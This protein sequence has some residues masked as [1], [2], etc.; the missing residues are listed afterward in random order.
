MI[1]S[2]IKK[3]CIVVSSLG[4]GGA[5][6]SSALLSEMLDELGFEVHII[7]VLNK[8]NY[9]Y[10]GKLLNLGLL[11]SKDDSSW[12][13]LK[14]LLV[15]K[16]YLKEHKFDYIIDNRT[17]IGLKE[18]FIAK[19]VYNDFKVI[20]GVHSYNIHWY[21]HPNKRLGKWLYKSAYQLVCVSQAIS[22]KLK[23][24]YDFQNLGVIHNAIQLPYEEKQYTQPLKKDYILFYGRIEDDIKNLSMLL[25]SYFQ[26]K[27]PESGIKLKIL[28]DGKDKSM[29][30]RKVESMQKGHFV[31][32]LDFTSQPEE[33][34]QNA[35]LT[36][37]TSRNEG[38]PMVLVESLSLGVPVV[39]VDC[40]SG[41]NEIIINE[42][43]G[44]LVANYDADAFTEALNRMIE[45]EDLY[46]NCK[47]NAI[48]SVEKFS[49]E[50]IGEQWKLLL[51]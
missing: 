40:E 10:K 14:R 3:V 1:K 38:F 15:F 33:I 29:L 20:Y 17:R 50:R 12:G 49:T 45:D 36:V 44:L 41:P 35:F 46:L 18:I 8:V 51:K 21:I 16:K 42:H 13:R 11:K 2:N 34:V 7:T 25:Q 37:L 19:Y 39:S 43:N 31:E 6:R 30:K 5:E 22:E 26:S 32:F 27:L 28:G 48:R 9:S 24:L 23:E 47:S 4:A